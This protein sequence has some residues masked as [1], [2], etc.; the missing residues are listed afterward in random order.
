MKFFIILFVFA[1]PGILQVK[2]E[3]TV[4]TKEQCVKEAYEINNDNSIPF[5]AACI[6]VMKDKMI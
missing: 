2:G 1:A 3:K 6:P 5:N 4:E